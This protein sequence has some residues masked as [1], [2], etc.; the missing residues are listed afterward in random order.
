[1]NHD[2]TTNTTKMQKPLNRESRECARIEESDEN[3]FAKIGVIR[4]FLILFTFFFVVFV[5][6][7]WLH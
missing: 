6:P 3:L 2:G 1:L 4:G 7:S 5:V